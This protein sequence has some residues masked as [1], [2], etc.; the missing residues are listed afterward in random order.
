MGRR[1][2]GMSA[3]CRAAAGLLLLLAV[4]GIVEV[5]HLDSSSFEHDT[6][7]ATGATTGDW[8]VSFY[9]SKECSACEAIAEDWGRVAVELKDRLTPAQVDCIE[10]PD[11]CRRFSIKQH[12]TLVL[13]RR[14]KLYPLGGER[15]VEGWKHFALGGYK[16]ASSTPVPPPLTIVDKITYEMKK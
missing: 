15:T 11:L 13:L 1:E 9:K 5:V 8:L 10:S 3:G 2:R 12:S 6:Q 7:A 14:G 16:S 4:G